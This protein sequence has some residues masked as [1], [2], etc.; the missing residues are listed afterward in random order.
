MTVTAMS[1]LA[2]LRELLF[3]ER[4]ERT[5]SSYT[6]DQRARVVS[7]NRAASDRVLAARSAISPLASCVLFR[8]AVSMLARARAAARDARL[9]YP[10]LA[11]LSGAADVLDVQRHPSG[12]ELADADL[13]CEALA[14][15]DPLYLDRLE[16]HAL[17]RLRVAL[18]R[19]AHVLRRHIEVRS[20]EQIRASRFQR[21]AALAALVPAVIWL[22]VRWRFM[23]EN[24]A[25]GKPV[26]ASSRHPDTPDG[27]EL[28]DGRRRFVFTV[29]TN[30]ED[31]PHVDIDL[32]GDFTVDRIA[33]YNRSDGWWDDCLPLVVELSRDGAT[34]SEIGRREEHFGF[35]V[36][37]TIEASGRVARIVR[38]RVARQSYLALGG[39]EVFGK[40]LKP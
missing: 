4:A 24:V 33:V 23:P 18:G 35:A 8:D 31:S 26:H 21:C 29:H 30:T 9:D 17:A 38:L 11:L 27:H 12:E 1:I 2:P 39:V 19:A 37:W 36:P 40:K 5:A 3:L 10:D 34:Y 32:L 22:G 14:T 15:D 13:V 7:L 28:V 20:R 6:S 16:R 25:A